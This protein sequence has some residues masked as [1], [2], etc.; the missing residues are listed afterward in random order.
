MAGKNNGFNIAIRKFATHLND[1]VK[2]DI[3]EWGKEKMF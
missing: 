3:F 1:F 2:A